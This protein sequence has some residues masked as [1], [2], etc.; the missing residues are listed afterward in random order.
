ML[1]T[2]PITALDQTLAGAFFLAKHGG[3]WASHSAGSV[4]RRRPSLPHRPAGYSIPAHAVGPGAEN[5]CLS[6]N[7]QRRRVFRLAACLLRG[8]ESALTLVDSSTRIADTQTTAPV[9]QSLPA[10][11]PHTLAPPTTALCRQQPARHL[12]HSGRL[13]IAVVSPSVRQYSLAS[14]L[15]AARLSIARITARIHST[16]RNGPPT[17]H[18]L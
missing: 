17:H 6:K 5:E 14:P 18:Q 4:A 1:P 10:R 11:T 2:L 9:L 8:V 12:R 16:H 15:A 7:E 13:S 3:S